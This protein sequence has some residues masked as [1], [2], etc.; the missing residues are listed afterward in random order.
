M[1]FKVVVAGGPASERTLALTVIQQDLM[2]SGVNAV[3]HGDGSLDAYHPHDVVLVS[4]HDDQPVPPSGRIH[5]A[6][7]GSIQPGSYVRTPRALARQVAGALVQ[8]GYAVARHYGDPEHFT[9]SR[10]ARFPLA[11]GE[12]TG[13]D[14]GPPPHSEPSP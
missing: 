7:F 13:D 6:I 8:A 14:S 9:A 10:E 12:I 1:C 4:D 3:L 11:S 2:H 5:V